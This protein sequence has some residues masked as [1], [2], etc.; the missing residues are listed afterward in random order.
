MLVLEIFNFNFL[1]FR[2][3]VTMFHSQGLLLIYLRVDVF[4]IL[5]DELIFVF[6][7]I[8]LFFFEILLL[9]FDLLLLSVG[10]HILIIFF[11]LLG[12][13]L[14]FFIRHSFAIH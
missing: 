9:F 13:L 2:F 10:L 6:F 1:S 8:L 11:L 14:F 12:I 3:F 5:F 7:D 4:R